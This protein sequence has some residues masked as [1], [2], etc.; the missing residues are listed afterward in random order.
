MKSMIKIWCVLLFVL[1][2]SHVTSFF[3]DSKTRVNTFEI[4]SVE[5]LLLEEKWDM[6]DSNNDD[7]P[8]FAENLV[9]CKTLTKDPKVKNVGENN[10]WVYLEVK[11]PLAN[12]IV[13]N[14]DG[15]RQSK[16]K[17]ELFS[18]KDV[19]DSWSLLKQSEND[20]YKSYVYGYASS[21]KILE[22]TDA[23]FNSVQFANVLEGQDLETKTFS[24]DVIAIA[25]Q[26]DETGTMQE[27]YSKYINQNKTN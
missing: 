9:P 12:V 21:L 18:L 19:S 3:T 27:A 22:T 1:L 2:V 17:I 14:D 20:D 13:V 7:I 23:L 4:G 5:I 10:A 8:D 16:K 11:I 6:M 24:I 25:I 26:T 15:S